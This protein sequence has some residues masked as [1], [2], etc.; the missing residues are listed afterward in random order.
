MPAKIRKVKE[1]KKKKDSVTGA[2]LVEN[3]NEF[4]IYQEKPGQQA[5]G[6]R[7][8]NDS[9]SYVTSGLLD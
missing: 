5:Q 9:V 1:V 8:T 7:L 2:I 3:V 6:I 4:Y